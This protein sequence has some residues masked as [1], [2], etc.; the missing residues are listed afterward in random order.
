MALRDQPYLPLYVQDFLTDEKLRECSA[1]SIGVYIMLMCLMHKSAEY[2]AILLRQKDRQTG[3]QTSDFAEKLTRHLPFNSAVIEQAL[4]ELLDEGVLSIEGDMLYQKRMVNDGKVSETRSK[5]G[6]KG[7]KVT[8]SKGLAAAKQS[9]NMSA[10]MSAKQSAKQSANSE[11]ENEYEYEYENDNEDDSN[12]GNKTAKKRETLLT[13]TQETRF[14]RFWEAYPRKVSKANAEKAWAKINPDDELTEKIISAIGTAKR[15]DERF[16]ETRFTPH[17]AS[18]LNA[19]SWENE[20]TEGESYEHFI[21][22]TGFKL[23]AI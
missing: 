7:A 11:Y 22:S 2:G 16:R 8:N 15:L 19:R 20:F 5:A 6:K 23:R 1:E 18:W 4:I 13:K 3:R 17:P 12:E 14:S 21:P 10:N 9:A